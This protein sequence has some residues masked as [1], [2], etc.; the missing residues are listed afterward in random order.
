MHF[1]GNP[2][3]FEGEWFVGSP[4]EVILENDYGLVVSTKARHHAISSKLKKTFEWD[5]KP[6]VVQ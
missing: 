6:L 3:L 1:L 5:G 2:P 4:A